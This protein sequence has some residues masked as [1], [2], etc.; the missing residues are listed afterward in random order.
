MVFAG[1]GAMLASEPGR[2]PKT[3]AALHGAGLLLMLVAGIGFAHKSG[4]GWPAWMIAKIA[5][6]IVL[7]AA[8]VLVKRGVLPRLA[9]LLLVLAIGVVAAWLARA[10]PF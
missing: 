7:G 9:A 5:C 10:K 8:P 1:L 2:T 6:W 4:Y 3:F